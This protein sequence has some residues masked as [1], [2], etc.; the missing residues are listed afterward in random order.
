MSKPYVY[1]EP[2]ILLPLDELLGRNPWTLI[3]GC[4]CDPE[5]TCEM[6]IDEDEVD[7]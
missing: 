7:S 6:H 4:K 3:Y 1:P 2:F 5:T